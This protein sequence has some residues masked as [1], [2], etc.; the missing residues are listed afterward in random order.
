MS[1]TSPPKAPLTKDT[2]PNAIS[3]PSLKKVIET[4][5]LVEL[6]VSKNP[7][8]EKDISEALPQIHSLLGHTIQGDSYRNDLDLAFERIIH[9]AAAPEYHAPI[10]EVNDNIVQDSIEVSAGAFE[11]FSFDEI[12]MEN[13]SDTAHKE[14]PQPAMEPL[15][16]TQPRTQ[17]LGEFSIGALENLQDQAKT[18]TPVAIDHQDDHPTHT[19]LMD[20]PQD[21]PNDDLIM[22]VFDRLGSIPTPTPFSNTKDKTI[23]TDGTKSDTLKTEAITTEDTLQNDS[24]PSADF[25]EDFNADTWSESLGAINVEVESIEIEYTP[26]SKNKERLATDF[27]PT[28][29]QKTPTDPFASPRKQSWI[30][31]EDTE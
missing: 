3:N 20:T 27:S 23:P 30:D 12:D 6:K 14:Y 25:T 29:D 5:A 28:E 31:Q 21:A 16:N 8:K 17:I 22:N 26:A 11:P 15:P 9:D 7:A 24:F 13:D 10:E 19:N 18:H 4:S 1:D 2:S